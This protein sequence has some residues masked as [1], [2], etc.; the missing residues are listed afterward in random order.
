[1]MNAAFVIILTLGI[2]LSVD[3]TS[4]PTMKRKPFTVHTLSFIAKRFGYF[5]V[6]LD[7]QMGFRILRSNYN[8]IM[9]IPNLLKI[10]L[11]FSRLCM[12][13][14]YAP[15]HIYVLARALVMVA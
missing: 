13:C 10:N 1:M 7:Q 9:S 3:G 15:I 12:Y 2:V 11:C 4:S 8:Y 6:T 14:C 5:Y